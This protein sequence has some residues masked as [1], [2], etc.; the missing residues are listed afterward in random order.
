MVTGM[1]LI[2]ISLFYVLYPLEVSHC[3]MS[4]FFFF[5][6]TFGSVVWNWNDHYDS[7]NFMGVMMTIMGVTRDG[8]FSGFP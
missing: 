6:W 3:P 8:R 7:D 2:P 5:L 4:K 1:R